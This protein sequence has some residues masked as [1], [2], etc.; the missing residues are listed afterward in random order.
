MN[1]R[2][3]KAGSI[4]TA[5]RKQAGR[6]AAGTSSAEAEKVQKLIEL[7]PN[8]SKKYEMAKMLAEMYYQQQD[9]PQAAL[10]YEKALEAAPGQRR[11]YSAL[12]SCALMQDDLPHGLD[13]INQAIAALRQDYKETVSA[14]GDCDELKTDI[15][16][17][18]NLRGYFNFRQ[19][20]YSKAIRDYRVALNKG[21]S[22]QGRMNDDIYFG[23]GMCHLHSGNFAAAQTNLK[24]CLAHNPDHAV[25]A[26]ELARLAPRVPA[27]K[28]RG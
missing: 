24:N 15:K 19:K 28:T 6:P 3:S 27:P 23:L 5:G 21:T 12:A 9:Y 25:A 7:M 17:F 14:A 13:F 8:D 16:S 10:Y 2:S 1:K 20:N 22:E 11:L 26:E 18:Y 4:G